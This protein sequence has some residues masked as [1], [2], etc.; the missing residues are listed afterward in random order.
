MGLLLILEDERDLAR[1]YARM[2]A[3]YGEVAIAPTIAQ[4]LAIIDARPI[5]A[6]LVD[7]GLPDGSGLDFVAY[8]RRRWPVVP[9][10]VLTALDDKSLV[11][12]AQALRA[13]FVF[14]PAVAANIVP[15]IRN[16]VASAGGVAESIDL[17]VKQLADARNMSTRE[18]EILNLAIAGVP[19]SAMAAELDVTENTLK[20]TIRRMLD[21]R[22]D[23]TLQDLARAVLDAALRLRAR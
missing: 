19:R 18:M 12:R 6:A 15:F 23:E 8:L 9:V 7:Q 22:G 14:K 10:L 2:L 20:T 3:P 5:E 13:E 16:A 1:S 4:A 17:A 11:N 21:R